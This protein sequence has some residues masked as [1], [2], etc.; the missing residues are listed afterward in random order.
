MIEKTPDV[1]LY[2][3]ADLLMEQFRESVRAAQ[4]RAHESGVDYTFTANGIRYITRPNG[5][6]EKQPPLNGE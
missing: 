1:K 5:E 4:K 6:I 2:E 3:N